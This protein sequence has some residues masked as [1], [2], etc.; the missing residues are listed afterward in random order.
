MTTDRTPGNR[1]AV[2]G[3]AVRLPGADDLEQLWA[4]LLA[5]VESLTELTDEQLRAAHVPEKLIQSPDYIRLRPMLADMEY[6]DAKYFGYHAREA[7]IAD[8]QQ[9]LFLEVCGTAMQQAGYGAGHTGPVGVYGGSGP[10]RY[11]YENVYDNQKVCDAVGDVAV[12]INNNQDYLA[13]RVA[14]ALGLTGPAV[15]IATACS[16]SLV[17]VHLACRALAGGECDMAIAGGVNIH[18]PYNRGQIWEP[19]SIYAKDGHI[20]AFDADAGGTNFGHGAGAVVLKRHEDALADRDDVLAVIIGSAVNNDGAARS[21]FTTP[22]QHMQAAVVTQALR[23]AGVHPDTI[24]YVEAH[25][26][27]TAVGD[28]IEVEALT[29]AYREAGAS[30]R[31]SCPIGSVKTNI[32]HLGPAAGVAGL[33]KAVL[34]LRHGQIPASLNFT[35]PN[36]RIDF[37]SSPFRVN[38]ALSPWPAG[39]TLRRAGVS[40]FGIGGTNAHVI[41]EEAQPPEI[42]EEVAPP[43]PGTPGRAWQ[44]LPLSARSD[45]ALATMRSELADFLCAH[46]DLSRAD[47]AHTLTSGRRALEWR[48]FLVDSADENASSHEGGQSHESAG[49][50]RS[51]GGP[52]CLAS[53]QTRVAFMFPGQGT[54]HA[55]MLAELHAGEPVVTRTVEEC[56]QLLLPHLGCDIRDAIFSSRGAGGPE[57][58]DKRLRETWL[59]QPALFVVEYALARLW[60]SWGLRPT[61]M[62][63]H[64][65]GE[66]VAACL[67]GVFTL[68]QA[69]ELVATRGRLVQ[70]MPPGAM[71]AVQMR[72][73]DLMPLL[74]D[75]VSLAAVNGPSSCVAAGPE[76]EIEF[77]AGWLDSHGIG[78]RR[79]RT[80]HAFH[81]PM[82][83][84]AAE[85]L[86]EAVAA[87][88]PQAPGLPFVST[89]TGRWI[90]AEEATD[91]GYWAAQLRG[92]VRFEQ[93]CGTLGE[94]GA[95]LLEVGPGQTLM[96]L[97]RQTLGSEA[98]ALHSLPRP[99]S[100]RSEACSMAL[101][102]GTV[103]A[104]G[105]EID[106]PAV[107]GPGRRRRVHLPTYP[108]QRQRFW[109][110]PDPKP[111]RSAAQVETGTTLDAADATFIPAW[112][113]SALAA[114]GPAQDVA[115]T[116]LVL[117]DGEAP[118]GEL[119]HA[120]SARGARVVRVRAGQGFADLGQGRYEI[121]P[122]S[123]DDYD[124]LLGALDAASARP[125]AVL[126]TWT[127]GTGDPRHLGFSSVL[128]LTQALMETWPGHRT[129]IRVVTSRCFNVSGADPVDPLKSLLIGPCRVV[130]T[131]S[132]ALTCRLIDVSDDMIAATA[133]TETLLAEITAPGAE[134]TVAYRGGRRWVEDFEHVALPERTDL[135]PALRRR[136]VYLITG[137]LGGI[138]L[139][140]AKELARTISARLVLVNRTRL[141]E[142]EEWDDYLL[143][144]H[145]DDPVSI[146]IRGVLEAEGHGAEVLI[147]GADVADENAMAGVVR[148][149]RERF[150]RVDG[151][152]HAAGIAGGGLAVMRPLDRAEAVLR[153]KVDGTLIIDRLLG[154]EIDLLVLFS[155]IVAVSGDYGMVDYCAANA[156]LDAFAQSRTSGYRAVA[157][158][159]CGWS[160]VGMIPRLLGAE[161]APSEPGG[162]GGSAR[163]PLLGR[164]V[165]GTG[166]DIEFSTRM[167]PGF[168]WVLTDHRMAGLPVLPGTAYAELITAAYREAVQDG[169]LEIRDLF[170]SRPLALETARELRVTG[171]R[172]GPDGFRFT[173]ASRPADDP[174]ASWEQNAQASVSA[175]DPATGV[176]HDLE[177]IAA[178]CVPVAGSDGE[179]DTPS[180]V[181]FGPH[182][183][184]VETVRVGEGE[185]LV[186]LSL[187]DGMDGDLADFTL[188]PALLDGAT[189]L[190]LERPDLA[191]RGLSFLPLAYDRLVVRGPLPRRVFSH[192]R[193]TSDTRASGD[194]DTYDIAVT[195]E[196]GNELV[197]IS[198]FAIRYIDPATVHESISAP[199][200]AGAPA[201]SSGRADAGSDTLISPREGLD[202]LWRLLNGPAEPQYVVCRERP[203]ERGRRMAESAVDIALTAKAPLSGQPAR[204][205]G[206][207]RN[208]AEATTKTEQILMELWQDAFG[209]DGLGLDE[210]FFDLGGN[211]LVAIQVAVK[212]R[213]RFGTNVPGVVILEFP[214][215]RELAT[216]VEDALAESGAGR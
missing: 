75:S 70:S 203:E 160:E 163:H 143:S 138:G 90:T 130:P 188:H 9:R 87:A 181:E 104:H 1:I 162:P 14:Y 199:G 215:V 106:W 42:L 72:E 155:S 111:A 175:A 170:F 91:P 99:G 43:E 67:S 152:F 176:R 5:G 123:R 145:A 149:A 61:A 45:T 81:T 93:A 193:A 92:T 21:S 148:L 200:W 26:T 164:R 4:N 95:V 108:Y 107:Q 194:I 41:L 207:P 150:G 36:P 128:F 77:L 206:A 214:T 62:V 133:A 17:A 23:A 141:P 121:D 157:V 64:S 165:L 89:L 166:G 213:E 84:P 197:G 32:G 114:V 66:Y 196:N 171:V 38:A 55:D 159:W 161:S 195:D 54:Q 79:L 112:R 28:P 139:E 69:L 50:V 73:S 186:E 198:G 59:A 96:T 33:V 144:H 37:E 119:A 15:S 205:R 34:A 7:E 135:P 122:V 82:M 105:A 39:D 131:E 117:G 154:K 183:R 47:V 80:S 142:R 51:I 153:P 68:P 209:V 182:W 208:F 57:A 125:E 136:G 76:E 100:E 124:R 168:H 40:S 172:S 132:S 118:T 49:S 110:E 78:S 179:R 120:L 97:A 56:A 146:R 126:H 201:A 127:A 204:E 8:P 156:F 103:W 31:Q 191:A 6:F 216:R 151:V 52:S 65:V 187:P 140:V 113:R 190:G 74:T 211:S 86:R 53:K 19:N 177:E 83:D 210:D 29:Q 63:G 173:V 60:Q 129:D 101:A 178:R 169:P 137:G 16:T 174:A 212:I 109:V 98:T 27:A 44:V 88:Q 12:E 102:A 85:A 30:G 11:S 192:V 48:T 20:R 115:D 25:G 18:L 180:P 184:V 189:A 147:L 35:T 58:L 185:Q 3:M 158:N 94:T 46:P 116:W 167:D 2:I 202:L 22:A 134:R 13:T 24:G 71:L 10:N